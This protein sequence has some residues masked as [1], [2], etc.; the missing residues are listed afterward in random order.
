M[1]ILGLGVFVY[2]LT[3]IKS[4]IRKQ[5]IKSIEIHIQKTRFVELTVERF[6]KNYKRTMRTV[7]FEFSTGFMHTFERYQ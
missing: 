7:Y 5:V 4:A 6:E 3:S 2:G 1:Y